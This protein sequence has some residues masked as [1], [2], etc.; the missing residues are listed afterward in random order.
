MTYRKKSAA[1]PQELQMPPNLPVLF[2]IYLRGI[3]FFIM[4]STKIFLQNKID[5][6]TQLMVYKENHVEITKREIEQIGEIINQLKSTLWHDSKE[7]PA[8]KDAD[9]K[10]EKE[11]VQNS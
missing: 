7:E 9:S 6:Y 4:K 3:K 8:E 1:L 10:T 11:E 5:Y 2:P